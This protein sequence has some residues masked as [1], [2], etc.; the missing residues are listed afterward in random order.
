MRFRTH[1]ELHL[2]AMDLPVED[3][4][5]ELKLGMALGD[6]LCD[7]RRSGPALSSGSRRMRE[8]ARRRL[9][10]DEFIDLQLSIQGRRRN[11]SFEPA[12]P[13]PGQLMD[14]PPS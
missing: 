14:P 12:L 2:A 5:G 8:R 13:A 11:L 6:A 4:A 1:P 9:A 10:L 7:A 3:S